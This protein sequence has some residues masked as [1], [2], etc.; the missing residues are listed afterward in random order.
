MILYLIQCPQLHVELEVSTIGPLQLGS[1]I[2]LSKCHKLNHLERPRICGVYVN[3]SFGKVKNATDYCITWI[4]QKKS[5]FKVYNSLL[6]F[7]TLEMV[8]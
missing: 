3:L 5:F 4:V 6:Y 1:D 2:T 8:L 7:S